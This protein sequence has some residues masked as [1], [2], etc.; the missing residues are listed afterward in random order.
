MRHNPFNY[1]GLSCACIRK[2]TFRR[3]F[4]PSAFANACVQSEV[5]RGPRSCAFA[6]EVQQRAGRLVGGKQVTARQVAV[7]YADTLCLSLET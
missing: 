2:D 5:M 7:R 6:N 3:I 4:H 1:M